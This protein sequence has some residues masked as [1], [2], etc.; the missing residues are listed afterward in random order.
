MNEEIGKTAGLVWQYLNEKGEVT[1]SQVKKN[2]K[3][4]SDMVNQ[5]IGWLARENK[6]EIQKKGN[7]YRISLK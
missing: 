7:S 4:S 6:L 5:A 1:L 2:V 3:A